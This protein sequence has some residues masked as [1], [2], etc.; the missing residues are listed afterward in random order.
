MIVSQQ[1]CLAFTMDA[2]ATSVFLV[3][4]MPVQLADP[5]I[6]S[7]CFLCA[8]GDKSAGAT[9]HCGAGLVLTDKAKAAHLFWISV[10]NPL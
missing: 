2:L 1:A 4:E 7:K 10:V 5:G 6:S 8:S 3:C 9:G